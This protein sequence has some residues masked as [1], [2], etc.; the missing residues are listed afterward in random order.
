MIVINSKRKKE[1][2]DD[3]KSWKLM[4]LGQPEGNVNID[5]L[6]IFGSERLSCKL[7]N[8]PFSIKNY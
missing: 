1:K 3:K 7:I 6:E 2:E 5:E 8:L 4:Y